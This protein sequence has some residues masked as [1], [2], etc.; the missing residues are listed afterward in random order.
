MTSED[1]IPFA[2]LTIAAVAAADCAS[3]EP[4]SALR[5]ATS[6]ITAPSVSYTMQTWSSS[7]PTWGA[8]SGVP[9]TSST[10]RVGTRMLDLVS[11]RG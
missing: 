3:L 8:T 6:H 5:N 11:C 10:S 2:P 7:T 4:A 9:C 1:I